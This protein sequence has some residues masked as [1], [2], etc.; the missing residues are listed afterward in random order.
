M[1][2]LPA[3]RLDAGRVI[4]VGNLQAGGAGKTPVVARIANEAA[5]RGSSVCILTRGY[6][7]RWEGPGGLLEPRERSGAPANA[8]E[9]G[10]EPA[11]LHELAPHAWI[12]VGADRAGQ[13]AR[14]VKAAGSRFDLVILDDGFQHWK[15][16]RDLDIVA[17]TDL[18]PCQV[19]YRDFR[20]AIGQAD[21]AVWTKGQRPRWISKEIP[22]VGMPMKIDPSADKGAVWLVTGIG[23]H[24]AAV[25]TAREAGYR[26]ARHLPFPDHA[27]YDIA[28]VRQLLKE[29][30]AAG[31]RLAVTGKDWVKWKQVQVHPS[32]VIVLEPR[33]ELL[34]QDRPLWEKILWA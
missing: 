17:I 19:P 20:H 1:G 4:S 15:V 16:A 31:C 33:L 9:C 29:S 18:G 13:Y 10:D 27:A 26:V 7:G 32:E 3:Q 24:A 30:H 28:T 25:E 14:A 22:L 8:L 11:L 12:A 23:D 6:R 34:E 5:A 21:L 2:A